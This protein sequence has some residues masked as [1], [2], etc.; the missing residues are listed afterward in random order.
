MEIIGFSLIAGFVS[1]GITALLIPRFIPVLKRLKMGQRVSEYALDEYKEKAVVPTMGGIFFV[2]VPVLVSLV[3]NLHNLSNRGFIL[4]LLAYLGYGLIGFLDDLKIIIEKKNDGLKPLHKFLMQL[5]LAVVFYWMYTAYAPSVLILPFNITISMGVLFAV[6]VLFMFTGASNAVNL[7]DG[8][9]GL[10]G[11][12]SV[13]AYIPYYIFAVQAQ[14]FPIAVFTAA[15]IGSLIGYLVYNIFPAR[16][17]MG[18]TGS[19]ALGGGLAALSL[20]L[21]KE[22]LLIVIGGVFVFE[23]V[24]VLIQQISVRCFKKKVF[25]FTPIHYAFVLAGWKEKSVVG[26]FWLLG[27]MCMVIGIIIGALL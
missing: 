22:L 16:I 3:F 15:I 12:T 1:F 17:I 18:D 26:F 5:F 23:T 25:R 6:V 20:V 7:T 2:V 27:C 24:C 9:D 8:M 11:G 19:L 13:L 21:K 10:A 4:V 14:E